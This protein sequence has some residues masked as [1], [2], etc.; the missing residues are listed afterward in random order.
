M[1]DA[2]DLSD[3]LILGHTLQRLIDDLTSISL[4]TTKSLETMDA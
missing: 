3:L 4:Q 1:D 2:D